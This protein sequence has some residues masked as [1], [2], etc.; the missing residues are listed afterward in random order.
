M[1]EL[2]I[3]G[4]GKRGNYSDSLL[5]LEENARRRGLEL[6]LVGDLGGTCRYLLVLILES[7]SLWLSKIWS[8]N[9]SNGMKIFLE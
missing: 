3:E 6:V 9:L 8:R 2:A 5:S 7:C 4:K 1:K